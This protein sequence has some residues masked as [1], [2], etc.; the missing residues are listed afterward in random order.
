MC[1]QVG[2]QLRIKQPD[3][4]AHDHSNEGRP[5]RGGYQN[6]LE[7]MTRG[8]IDDACAT[9]DVGEDK[10][11]GDGGQEQ[12]LRAFARITQGLGDDNGYGEVKGC[13]QYLGS[14]GI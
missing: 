10:D 13:R 4:E 8:E 14:K 7:R 1:D 6:L 3:G 12:G 11:K 9:N 2:R 5:Y